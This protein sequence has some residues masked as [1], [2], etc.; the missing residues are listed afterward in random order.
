[1]Q[2]TPTALPEVLE[3]IPAR[4]GDHRG[5][6]SETWNRK[7]LAEAGIEID[8][9]QDNH[10]L[11][12][13]RHTLRGLHYQ[14]APH[15]QDK[16]VRVIAGAV[17]DVAADIRKGSPTYGQWVAVPLTAEAGNQLLIPKGFAHG[18]LT[19]TPDVQVLYK[20]SDFYAPETDAG[21]RW[22]DPTLA[23]DWGVDAADLTLSNKDK[24]APYLTDID[25]PFIYEGT[26]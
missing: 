1:M 10:S 25:P 13:E 9:C 17:L 24:L 16:L 12:A 15:A 4:F 8:F 18:F 2:I 7:T 14:K 6:F 19:L 23:V 3:I 20:C 5:Y 22:D 11:S 26:S 21:I